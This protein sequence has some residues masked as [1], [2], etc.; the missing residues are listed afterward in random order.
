MKQKEKKKKKEIKVR[1]IISSKN[2]TLQESNALPSLGEGY[3]QYL[4]NGYGYFSNLLQEYEYKK[5]K[6]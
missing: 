6:K 2:I 4:L 5:V 3:M 1:N